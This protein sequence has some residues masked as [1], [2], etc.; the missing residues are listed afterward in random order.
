MGKKFEKYKINVQYLNG[1]IEDINMAGINTSSY[2]KMLEVYH[3]IK[4]TYADKVKIINFIGIDQEGKMHIKFTKEIKHQ[5]RDELKKDVVDIMDNI[6]K[7]ML[8]IKEKFF[9]HSDLI[10][11]LNKKE[12]IKLHELESLAEVKYMTEVDEDREILRIGKELKNIRVERRWHKNQF[13]M[14]SKLGEQR[15]G[16][17]NINFTHLSNVFKPRFSKQNIKPLNMKIAEELRLYKEEIIKDKTKQLERL[18]K[19]FDKIIVDEADNRLICYNKA[20][21]I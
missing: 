13:A 7:E 9:Y 1:D 3:R 14:I 19:N 20:K 4:N 2:S 16:N 6:S 12:D 5:G 10:D 21:A 17:E 8:L 11:G 18:Q 15:I